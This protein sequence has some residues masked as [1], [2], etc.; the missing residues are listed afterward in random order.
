[1]NQLELLDAIIRTMRQ[2]ANDIEVYAK[3]MT[4]PDTPYSEIFDPKKDEPAAEK[5]KSA[6]KKQP[7][8]QEAEEPVTLTDVRAVLAEKSRS[9]FKE[10]VKLLLQKHGAEKL[11][12]LAESE[13]AAVLKEAQALGS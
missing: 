7:P 2:L 4:D 10:E 8:K 12:E 6:A 1:M 3:S 5:P 9:G 13:Y 11:S